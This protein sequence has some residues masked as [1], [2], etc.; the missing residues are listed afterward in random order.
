MRDIQMEKSKIYTLLALT[1]IA[2]I[3]ISVGAFTFMKDSFIGPQGEQGIQGIQG[4][5]G[6][7]GEQGIQGIQGERGIQGSIGLP[8]EPGTPELT[9]MNVWSTMYTDRDS[10]F[11][12]PHLG[13]SSFQFASSSLVGDPIDSHA[14]EFYIRLEGAMFGIYWFADYC[15]ASGASLSIEVIDADRSD[16]W[17]TY[18]VAHKIYRDVEAERGM[19][20]VFGPGLYKVKIDAQRNR[21][22]LVQIISYGGG[23]TCSKT[24]PIDWPWG[25]S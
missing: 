7:Q 19:M 25:V 8:G 5:Q 2:S 14:G 3:A 12:M 17:H 9:K 13:S 6:I 24:Q 1:A 22:W 4:G 18:T 11:D 15:E 20:Y 10:M 23:G 16:M 21:D